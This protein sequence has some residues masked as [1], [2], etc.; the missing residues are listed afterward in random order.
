M[1]V[2]QFRR[3]AKNIY[4]NHFTDLNMEVRE[5]PAGIP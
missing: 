3:N 1:N 4:L 2:S 5:S